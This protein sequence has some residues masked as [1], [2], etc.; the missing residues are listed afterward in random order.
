MTEHANPNPNPG[1]T[2]P[3]S[4]EELQYQQHLY[5]EVVYFFGGQAQKMP[6]R[7]LPQAATDHH[8]YKHII[9]GKIEDG[10]YHISHQRV[11]VTVLRPN[12]WAEY[13][14]STN[15][16]NSTAQVTSV[17]FLEDQARTWKEV[18]QR[19]GGPEDVYTLLDL[20]KGVTHAEAAEGK[21]PR[22]KRPNTIIV[23]N[24]YL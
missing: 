15:R 8:Q 20:I 12:T 24:G 7:T 21:G 5:V 14:V 16:R 17:R 9:S 1:E 6:V 18:W 13:S 4:A 3:A 2:G 23:K 11:A 22:R 19:E 10:Q